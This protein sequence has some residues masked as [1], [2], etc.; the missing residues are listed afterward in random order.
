MRLTGP[1]PRGI[2]VTAS[3]IGR[4]VVYRT[5]PN[6]EPEQGVITSFN[7]KYVFVRYGNGLRGVATDPDDLDWL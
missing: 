7:D 3:D 2:K 1:P 4:G 5:A 6:F